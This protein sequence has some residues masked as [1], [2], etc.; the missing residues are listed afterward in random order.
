M[1]PWHEDC[2]L[3]MALPFKER[4]GPAGTRTARQERSRGPLSTCQQDRRRRIVQERERSFALIQPKSEITLS[5]D[6]R[7]NHAVRSLNV[8]REPE[9]ALL[10]EA[11]RGLRYGSV[12]IIVQDGIIVQVDRTE[13]KRITHAS[14]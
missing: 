1:Y 7:M 13:K 11:L 10:R 14:R 3:W 8:E 12:T 2:S 6:P 9:L 4:A 5:D